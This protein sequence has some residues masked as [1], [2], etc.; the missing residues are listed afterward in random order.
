LLCGAQGLEFRELLRPGVGV[1]AAHDFIRRAVPALE[2]DRP[3]TPDIEKLTEMVR[4]GSL[5]S[6]VEEAVGLLEPSY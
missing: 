6:R 3:Q 1:A 4:D 2:Y 5:V